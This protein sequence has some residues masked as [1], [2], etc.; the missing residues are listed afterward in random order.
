MFGNHTSPRTPYFLLVAV[1]L[2]AFANS[3]DGQS[4][5]QIVAMERRVETMNR[6]AKDYEREEMQREG[7]GKTTA[8]QNKRPAKV[9]RAEIEEDLKGLQSYYNKI[10]TELQL[11][12]EISNEFAKGSAASIKN[13]AFRLRENLSLP[14]ADDKELALTES[15]PD[16]TRR[17]LASLCKH[18]YAFITNPIFETTTGLNVEHSVKARQSLDAIISFAEKIANVE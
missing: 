6:Q 17:G 11:K 18:I 5:R 14:K 13:H 9:I 4:T 1:S 15:L 16:G 3:V 12:Q 2:F 7:N 10:V 8:T